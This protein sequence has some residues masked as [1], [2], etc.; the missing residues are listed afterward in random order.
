MIRRINFER[1]WSI[2]LTFRKYENILITVV[3]TVRDVA[4][5]KFCL[6]NFF[7]SFPF[8]INVMKFCDHDIASLTDNNSWLYGISLNIKIYSSKFCSPYQFEC[9]YR[10]KYK[11]NKCKRHISEM[12][13]TY[14]SIGGFIEA[15]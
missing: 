13:L 5:L 6:K 11:S 9:L 3:F 12:N 4:M 7:P 14:P 8:A 15:V 1:V 2:L 10:V